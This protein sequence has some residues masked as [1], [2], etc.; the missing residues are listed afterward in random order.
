MTEALGG[1]THP[2]GQG[3]REKEDQPEQMSKNCGM[4]IIESLPAFVF[5]A[6][7]DRLR[8]GSGFRRT[9]FQLV[10]APLETRAPRA[11]IA[12]GRMECWP[13]AGD[14]RRAPGP[15]G[16]P[17]RDR[18]APRTGLGDSD[19]TPGVGRGN[20]PSNRSKADEEVAGRDTFIRGVGSGHIFLIGR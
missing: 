16:R 11:E 9:I 15:S 1:K 5:W 3:M 7:A 2:C 10:S 6:P 4:R 12:G 20:F 14:G 8:A 17:M 19:G 13:R 18:C